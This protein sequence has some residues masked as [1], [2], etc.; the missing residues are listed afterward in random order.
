MTGFRWIVPSFLLVGLFLDPANAHQGKSSEGLPAKSA[1]QQL[2]AST[3]GEVR[4]IGGRRGAFRIYTAQ[5]GTQGW[6]TFGEF[7]TVTDAQRQVGQWSKLARVITREQKKD[8]SGRLIGERI[9]ATTQNSKSKMKGFLIIRRDE[10]K[11]YLID[12]LSLPTATL[13]EKMT[14]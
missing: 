14:E 5:D 7:Q 12:S 1:E 6:L 4:L 2:E 9:V 11:C 3:A 10:T 8:E 13:V